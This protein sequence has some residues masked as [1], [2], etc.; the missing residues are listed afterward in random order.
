MPKQ[1]VHM[2]TQEIEQDVQALVAQ[3]QEHVT[4][5]S[6]AKEGAHGSQKEE[7]VQEACRSQEER[8]AHQFCEQQAHCFLEQEAHREEEQARQFCEKK[9]HCSREQE[10]YQAQ[11][12]EAQ[13]MASEMGKLE[14]EQERWAKQWQEQLSEFKRLEQGVLVAQ[15]E[16][17][18]TKVCTNFV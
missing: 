5:L 12:Q 9:A 7:E 2:H 6:R 18:Q 1:Q 10:A 13:K 3:L 17:A 15:E 14:Q 16:R 4:S 11:E 8:Q